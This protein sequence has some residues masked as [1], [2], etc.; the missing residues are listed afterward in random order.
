MNGK[1]DTCKSFFVDKC[2]EEV[3]GK[4]IYNCV[5]PK[6]CPLSCDVVIQ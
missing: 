4:K 6:V 1:E 2:W 5:F 3:L